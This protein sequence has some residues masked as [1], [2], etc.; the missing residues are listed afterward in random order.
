MNSVLEFLFFFY[1]KSIFSDKIATGSFDKT[2]MLWSALNGS[3]LR[4]FCGHTAEVVATEFS[5]SNNLLVSSSMDAT[6]RIFDI[7]IG[8]EIQSYEEHDGA[9]IAAH[10]NKNENLLL[11]G[12]FDSNAYLWDLRTKK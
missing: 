3:C 5:H 2:T 10:F 1:K 8:L 7:E 11:T 4:T 12:S 6:A 9:V